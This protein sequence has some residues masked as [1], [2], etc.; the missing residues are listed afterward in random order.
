MRY[1]LAPAVA[2]LGLMLANVVVPV[3]VYR[4]KT[5]GFPFPSEVGT[6]S[7]AWLSKET[8]RSLRE[9]PVRVEPPLAVAVPKRLTLTNCVDAA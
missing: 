9:I 1:R 2:Y 3:W 8:T 5:S 7:V 6:R 4:T